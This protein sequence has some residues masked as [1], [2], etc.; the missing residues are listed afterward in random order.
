MSNIGKSIERSRNGNMHY[1]GSISTLHINLEFRL[2]EN[3]WSD[4]PSAPQ[5]LIMSETPDG[6]SVQIGA[7]WKKKSEKVGREPMEFFSLTFDDPSFPHS[8]NV[9]AF[10]APDS[11]EWTISWRRRQ[12]PSAA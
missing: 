8:L 7:A 3:M 11:D 5:F 1:H 12:A 4:N 10:K 2:E 6:A 9:A